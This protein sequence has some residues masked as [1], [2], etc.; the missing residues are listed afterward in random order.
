MKQRELQKR[1]VACVLLIVV[2]RFAAA[3][4]SAGLLLLDRCCS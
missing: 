2:G 1:E 3:E 4:E